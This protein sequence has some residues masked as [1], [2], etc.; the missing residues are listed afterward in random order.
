[1]A[2]RVLDRPPGLLFVDL[3]FAVGPRHILVQSLD[4]HDRDEAAQTVRTVPVPRDKV[5]GGAGRDE[6]R[7]V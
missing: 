1:M 2:N 7:I 4:F 3:D 5:L 6:D